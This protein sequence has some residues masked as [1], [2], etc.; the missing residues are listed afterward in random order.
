MSA[1]RERDLSDNTHRGAVLA[2]LIEEA[3]RN[4]PP[5]LETWTSPNVDAEPEIP[6]G[7]SPAGVWRTTNQLRVMAQ[8]TRILRDAAESSYFLTGHPTTC[9]QG[10][11]WFFNF[12]QP[13]RALRLEDYQKTNEYLAACA[14]CTGKSLGEACFDVHRNVSKPDRKFTQVL[15]EQVLP[16]GQRQYELDVCAY[17]VAHPGLTYAA[18]P[19][20]MQ[21]W[22]ALGLY[23]PLALASV[24]MP[25]LAHWLP[26][27]VHRTDLGA[28]LQGAL[29]ALQFPAD[30]DSHFET[31][32]RLAWAWNKDDTGTSDL[33]S[34]TLDRLAVLMDV[35]ANS[36]A[37][38]RLS[39]CLR[40]FAQRIKTGDDAH[41]QNF[42]AWHDLRACVEDAMPPSLL[43]APLAKP[44]RD[45]WGYPR[46]TLAVAWDGPGSGLPPAVHFAE[47]S[48]QC[49]KTEHMAV[50]SAHTYNP[51]FVKEC[52][53]H[54]TSQRVQDVLW[55]LGEL[56]TSPEVS[57]C[58]I[59]PSAALAR[60]APHASPAPH[61]AA[62]ALPEPEH[63]LS[64]MRPDAKS[65]PDL[66]RDY[67]AFG[68]A[69]DSMVPSILT[70]YYPYPSTIL[71]W[72][73]DTPPR[74]ILYVGDGSDVDP[75][76][77]SLHERRKILVNSKVAHRHVGGIV[78]A[79][80]SSTE[81]EARSCLRAFAARDLSTHPGNTILLTRLDAEGKRADR[82]PVIPATC[83]TL[84][85]SVACFGLTKP[86]ATSVCNLHES[87]QWQEDGIDPRYAEKQLA[88]NGFRYRD[89][90]AV[91]VG[92]S[93]QQSRLAC[94]AV[95]F[96]CLHSTLLP[97][98]QPD[99]DVKWVRVSSTLYPDSVTTLQGASLRHAVETRYIHDLRMLPTEGGGRAERCNCEV[100]TDPGG[101]VA[102]AYALQGSPALH[103]IHFQCDEAAPEED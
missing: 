2:A 86:E 23:Y 9:V 75:F 61:L 101:S 87:C 70:H 84:A 102:I 14:R 29:N 34:N 24:Y 56:A 103:F 58:L 78:K 11:E 88:Q 100:Y 95:S 3:S 94:H 42:D 38:P 46:L 28:A 63:A 18:L 31:L 62:Q 91:H 82:E 83:T 60:L 19:A 48:L 51:P 90:T 80:H 40:D 16:A 47:S 98:I 13:L 69:I 36:A 37:R 32:K 77:R 6:P 50:S 79:P 55:R 12:A 54:Q 71:M 15:A 35:K 73:L 20:R 52:M 65:D 53:L 39:E 7:C 92:K 64:R 89:W 97:W 33:L 85:E 44:K 57:A 45:T 99:D 59:Q 72:R 81:E 67:Q 43:S 10:L 27:E 76:D 1:R 96:E 30:H 25:R 66:Q 22:R 8:Y 17:M 93:T 68:K 21:N 41:A 5:P 49:I 4:A 74:A 26:D